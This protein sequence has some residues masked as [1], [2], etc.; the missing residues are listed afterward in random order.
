MITY[1]AFKRVVDREAK[2]LFSEGFSAKVITDGEGWALHVFN[3]DGSEIGVPVVREK[4]LT[5]A[6]AKEFSAQA[7]KFVE[8]EFEGDK[9]MA[10]IAEAERSTRQ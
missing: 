1:E 9:V 8:D 6:D 5:A 4:M 7:V 3:P 2:A 10:M